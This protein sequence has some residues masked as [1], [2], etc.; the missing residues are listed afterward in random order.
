MTA[1]GMKQSFPT[2]YLDDRFPPSFGHSRYLALTLG[3]RKK[4]TLFLP[5][6]A[7]VA[8]VGALDWKATANPP[9]HR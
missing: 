5:C 6:R 8:I 9:C 2:A 4:E 7:A 3:R 1:F